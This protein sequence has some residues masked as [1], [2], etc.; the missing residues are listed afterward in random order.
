MKD[1]YGLIYFQIINFEAQLKILYNKILQI[2]TSMEFKIIFFYT[3][4][5][6]KQI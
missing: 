5:I 1:K 2:F 4:L 6:I 3:N